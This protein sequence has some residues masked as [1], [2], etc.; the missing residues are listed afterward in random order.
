MKTRFLTSAV[1]IT[2]LALTACG[3]E[4]ATA[5]TAPA[6]TDLEVRALDGIAWNSKSYTAASTDGSITLFAANDSSLPHN[7]QVLD[8]TGKK[9]GKQVDIV[10][11]G[12]SAT[13][14]VTIAPGNYRIVCEVPG[15]TNMN[16]TLTVT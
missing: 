3:G 6:N 8:S 7:L 12:S 2:L 16:S 9:V 14:E 15:H 1:A 13:V 5:G 10:K 11:A 4:H